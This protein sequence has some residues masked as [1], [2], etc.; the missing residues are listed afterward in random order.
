VLGVLLFSQA[1]A[2]AV[3]AVLIVARGEG[4]PAAGELLPAAIGGAAGIVALGAL[5]RALSIGTMSIVAPISATG[6]AVPVI[7][8]IG[9]GDR[10]GALQIAGIA[11]ALVGVVLASREA[12]EDA[13]RARDARRSVGLALVAAAGFGT[14]LTLIDA[15]A[16]ASVP[17]ALL[18]ARC[19]AV[20]LIAVVAVAV[21][22]TRPA[23]ADLPGLALVGL[24]D[25]GA[26]GL[27]AAATT[28]GLLSIVG[29]LGSLYP[30]TT[31]LLAR[32]ILRERP[33]RV[34]E[35]GILLALGGVALIAAG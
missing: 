2:L 1:S 18:A 33:R 24:L 9:R 31:V 30:V 17:W 29:V 8:G 28:K 11:A 12:N 10:P 25:L 20:A 21:R 5:Y 4:P 34:Q 27:Y 32:A 19:T 14:F 6:A 15:A 16:Q 22:P 13:E 35:A 26:N 23:R 3:L 7:A